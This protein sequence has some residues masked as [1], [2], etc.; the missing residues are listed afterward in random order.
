MYVLGGESSA[1]AIVATTDKIDMSAFTVAAKTSANLSTNRWEAGGVANSALAGYTGGGSTATTFAF[2]ATADKLTFSNDTAAAATTA[3]LSIARGQVVGIS[4]R[5]T[6]GYYAGG[7]SGTSGTVVK[8]ATADKITFSGDVTAA[9]TT[10]NLS[11]ARGAP[12]GGVTDGSTKGYWSGGYTGTVTTGTVVTGDKITFSSDTTTAATT[13]NISLSRCQGSGGS[14]G[15]TKGYFAGGQTGSG[16]TRIDKIT[17]S[18]DT[19]ASI[20]TATMAN[21]A[22][23]PGSDGKNALVAG[24][25]NNVSGVT[26]AIVG[27]AFATDTSTGGI[28]GSLSISRFYGT[29]LTT[30]GL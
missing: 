14:D 28:G 20:T 22:G 16:V 30:V 12:C 25:V 3:N 18:I 10:A 4:E 24:G 9:V 21:F 8:L 19:A 17:F 29:G 13:A 11:Q 27:T 1:G 26:D 5:S 2:K 23:A 15:V 7:I 6:K